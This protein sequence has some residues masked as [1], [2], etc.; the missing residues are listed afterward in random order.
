MPWLEFHRVNRIE[1]WLNTFVILSWNISSWR[2]RMQQIKCV[3]CASEWCAQTDE[4]L[5]EKSGLWRS[6]QARPAGEL[7]LDSHR[8]LLMHSF[9]SRTLMTLYL[10]SSQ[11]FSGL[12]Y[13][14]KSR[15]LSKSRLLGKS[16][17]AVRCSSGTSNDTGPVSPPVTK[18]A[19][20][21][22]TTTATTAATLNGDANQQQGNTK[23]TKSFQR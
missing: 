19:D 20:T 14:N 17:D 21:T 18:A 16:L 2:I 6:I 23:E 3:H 8:F 15:F 9:H 11:R 12:A 22:T 7:V 1:G 5:N 4:W 13:R 10:R